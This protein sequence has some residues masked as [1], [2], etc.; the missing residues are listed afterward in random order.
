MATAIVTQRFKTVW[1][2]N[3]MSGHE[4]FTTVDLRSFRVQGNFA[5]DHSFGSAKKAQEYADWCNRQN[6]ECPR[7]QRELDFVARTAHLRNENGEF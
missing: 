3:E 4:W 5:L 2:K 6:F 7:S 1:H